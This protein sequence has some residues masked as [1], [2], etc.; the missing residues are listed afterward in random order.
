MVEEE[1]ALGHEAGPGLDSIQIIK[2]LELSYIVD[3][4]IKGYSHFGERS[5]SFL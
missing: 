5:G 1:R 2:D 4:S 3:R